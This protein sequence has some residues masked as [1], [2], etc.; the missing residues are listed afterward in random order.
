[1]LDEDIVQL[2]EPLSPIWR[3]RRSNA[4]NAIVTESCD[5]SAWKGVIIKIRFYVV[6]RFL[7]WKWVKSISTVSCEPKEDSKSLGRE[8]ICT[9]GS[10]GDREEEQYQ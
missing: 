8:K 9:R 7:S 5:V 4:N 3:G 10:S 1:M 2:A 6:N